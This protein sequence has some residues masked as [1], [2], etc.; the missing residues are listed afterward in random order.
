MQPQSS[1]VTVTLQDGSTCQ[2]PIGS[3]VKGYALDHKTARGYEIVGVRNDG[4]L[5]VWEVCRGPGTD[6]MTRGT[7]LPVAG[8][9][10]KGGRGTPTEAYDS[11]PRLHSNLTYPSF[12]PQSETRDAYLARIDRSSRS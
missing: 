12:D 9:R 5:E 10:A 3:F 1:L 11:S 4:T 8:F 2:L 7:K 6:H